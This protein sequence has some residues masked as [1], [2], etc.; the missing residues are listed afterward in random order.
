MSDNETKAKHR[1]YAKAY[2]ERQKA[3]GLKTYKLRSEMTEDELTAIRERQKREAAAR[4]ARGNKRKY[5]KDVYLRAK[6][7]R[8]ALG[9]PEKKHPRTDEAKAKAR[10]RYLAEKDT[11]EYKAKRKEI[12]ARRRAKLLAQGIKPWGKYT[13]EQKAAKREYVRNRREDAKA[14][15]IKLPGDDW[16]KNNPER[17]RENGKKWRENNPEKIGELQRKYQSNRRNTSWGK[18]TNRFHAILQVELRQ[19]SPWY[20][21]DSKYTRALGYSFYDLYAH[22]A[23]Q[24]KEGMSWDNW[25]DWHI[26]HIKPL[27]LFRYESLDDPLFKEAWALSNLRPLWKVENLRKGCK[28]N[29]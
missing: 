5:N 1:E 14:N 29:P 15:G 24:F 3:K 10:A 11:P 22:I 28:Y 12:D 26:D 23:S 9:L 18:I 20:S 17:H 2:R 7:K 6:E 25:G 19:C 27:K 13:E 21:R 4:C 8:K 16:A